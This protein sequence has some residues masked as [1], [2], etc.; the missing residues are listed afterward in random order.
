LGAL[1]RRREPRLENLDAEALVDHLRP[2]DEH[3]PVVV[4]AADLRAPDAVAEHRPNACKLV[5]GNRLARTAP[6]DDDAEIGAAVENLPAE[7]LAEGWVVDDVGADVSRPVVDLVAAY[8]EPR[9]QRLFEGDP[10][11]VGGD[12]D[13]HPSS[14]RSSTV[15]AS[16]SAGSPDTN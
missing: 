2:D 7:V 3:V 8:S 15:S 1:E 11:V 5:A 16:M 6:A 13:P 9:E 14:A 4:A 12:R 10:V